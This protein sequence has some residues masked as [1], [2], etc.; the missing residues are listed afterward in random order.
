MKLW[1]A[2]QLES[3]SLSL[4]LNDG[5]C[6]GFL[7][8]YQLGVK[9]DCICAKNMHMSNRIH[10]IGFTPTYERFHDDNKTTFI[11]T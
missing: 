2:I 6:V 1:V 10:V 7:W 8:F 11:H 9:N 5:H 3:L 4:S